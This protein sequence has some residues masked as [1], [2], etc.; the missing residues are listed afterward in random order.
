MNVWIKGIYIYI[1]YGMYYF[2]IFCLLENEIKFYLR[3]KL[4][5][6][7]LIEV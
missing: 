1:V 7:L 2:D 5:L 4:G 6:W 3:I